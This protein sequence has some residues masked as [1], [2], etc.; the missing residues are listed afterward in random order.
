MAVFNNKK[1]TF[2]KTLGEVLFVSHWTKLIL[3]G[4]SAN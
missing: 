2:S 1:I 3:A 4:L